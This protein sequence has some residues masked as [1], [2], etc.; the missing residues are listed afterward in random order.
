MG[1]RRKS[2]EK[3]DMSDDFGDLEDELMTL[4]RNECAYLNAPTFVADAPQ[5]APPALPVATP[6]PAARAADAAPNSAP[7]SA[8]APVVSMLDLIKSSLSTAVNELLERAE[9]LR[10]LHATLNGEVCVDSAS[11]SVAKEEDERIARRKAVVDSLIEQRKQAITLRVLQRSRDARAGGAN[12]NDPERMHAKLDQIEAQSLAES[13]RPS[14]PVIWTAL[15]E[16]L[17][18]EERDYMAKSAD[19]IFEEQLKYPKDVEEKHELIRTHLDAIFQHAAPTKN[20]HVL[21]RSASHSIGNVLRDFNSIFCACYDNYLRAVEHIAIVLPMA[22]ADVNQVAAILAQ[23]LVFKY[24]ALGEWHEFVQGCVLDAL[25]VHLQPTLHGLYVVAFAAEDSFVEQRALALRE[26][27]LADFGVRPRFRLDDGDASDSGANNGLLDHN[28]LRLRSLRR[29]EAAIYIM[30]DLPNHRS[31][32]E[33]L[34]LLAKLCRTIDETIRTYYAEL[35]STPTPPPENLNLTADDLCSLLAF[36]LVMSPAMCRHVYSQ[37][38][39]LGSFLPPSHAAG[40]E[41][42]AIATFTSAVRFLTH[43]TVDDALKS[44]LHSN[45]SMSAPSR[46]SVILLVVAVLHCVVLW[47]LRVSVSELTP[48]V[49]ALT[50]TVYFRRESNGSIFAL[51]S[52]D[53]SV[54]ELQDSQLYAR[55]VGLA[56][57][58]SSG[59]IFWS[60]GR[61]IK[62]KAVDVPQPPLPPPTTTTL[63]GSLAHVTWHGVNFGTQRSD[64]MELRVLDV[65]CVSVLQWSPTMVECIVALPTTDATSVTTDNCVIRTTSGSMTGFARNYGEMRAYGYPSPI[66]EYLELVVR[67]LRP[68]ALAFENAILPSADNDQWLYWSN[69]LDGNI[70]R[71]SL[72]STALEVVQ[73]RAWGVR[74][75]ALLPASAQVANGSAVLFFS[76]EGK[77]KIMQRLLPSSNPNVAATVL[78][79]GLSSPRGLAVSAT[80][81][82]LFFAEKTGRIFKVQLVSAPQ[83]LVQGA[84]KRVLTLPTTTRLDGLAVDS[85]NLY[86]CETNSNVVA[87]ASID[88]FERQVLVGGSANLALSWP[89]AV[90]LRTFNGISNAL[91]SGQ[92]F[93]SE[94]TG[95]ISRGTAATVIINEL[96]APTMIHLD[97]LLLQ[98]SSQTHNSHVHFY[99][100]E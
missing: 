76:L 52:R 48:V 89:R 87:R 24:K 85:S 26:R 38:A 44:I 63:V 30:N 78:L 64:L 69:T 81:S 53:N 10:V 25:F 99:G 90:V 9:Q 60:D 27:R 83:S 35:R 7:T 70:Y 2:V 45:A 66:V 16:L 57:H 40:E 41:G 68:Q 100:L 43:L 28:E 79:T 47:S 82:K 42:F 5:S 94:Y 84:S 22:A 8:P 97:Q 14:S 36:V 61:S 88:A 98:A 62:Y 71:S 6:P 55:Y 32:W 95:R 54:N 46:S 23:V 65:P 56:M 50:S 51:D 1:N 72:T 91:D 49:Q 73:T 13:E 58:Q 21:R 74:G 33:K 96:T 80:Q 18:Q 37:L 29:Y 31:P 92:F 19:E 39:I 15:V 11:S 20:G 75:L 86:W 77:G 4:E 67:P 3:M 12:A 17:T 59:R 93:F 34:A